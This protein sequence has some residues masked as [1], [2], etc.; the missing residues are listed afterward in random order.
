MSAIRYMITRRIPF[1][2]Y[3]PQNGLAIGFTGFK[4]D[5][6]RVIAGA[7]SFGAESKPVVWENG[8]RWLDSIRQWSELVESVYDI[9]TH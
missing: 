9:D 2:F 4:D 1:E 3:G 5:I 6:I 7:K 8:I